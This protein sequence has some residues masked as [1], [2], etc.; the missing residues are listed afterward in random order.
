MQKVTGQPGFVD[1]LLEA[2]GLGRNGDLEAIGAALDW[3]RIEALVSGLRGA[4]EGRPGY[5]PLVMVKALLLQL[6][7]NLSDPRL[8]QALRDS[9]SFRRFAGL[10][11]HDGTPDHSV[12]CRFRQALGAEGLDGALFAEVNR[13]LEGRGLMVKSGTILDA[14][15]VAAAVKKPPYRS[16]ADAAAPSS[17]DG[18]AAW[19]RKDGKSCFGYKAHIGVDEGSGLI[20]SALLTPARTYESEVAE[21]LICGDERAVYADRA[22]EK[23]ERRIALKARGIKDRIM[24]RA[25]KHHPVLPRWKAM[26]NKLISPIRSAVERVFG[27]WKRSY[28]YVR[29]RYRG[30]KRNAVHLNLLAAAFNLRKAAA[31]AR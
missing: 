5:P 21:A 23:K 9:I 17:V 2:E 29:V 26:R 6:W 11:M 14:T 8:E 19:T 4:R 20:R 10:A 18:E 16:K 3:S 15:L 24:H 12:I 7:H 22:Y 13:Q 1:A 30:L 27:T 28:G 31:I 25:N